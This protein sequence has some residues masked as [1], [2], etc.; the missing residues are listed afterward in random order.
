MPPAKAPAVSRSHQA[1]VL[2]KAT[3]KAQP[4]WV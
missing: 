3:L 1:A 2:T 4:S